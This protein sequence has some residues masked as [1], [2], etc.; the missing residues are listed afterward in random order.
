MNSCMSQELFGMIMF[1]TD[2]AVVCDGAGDSVQHC[3]ERHEPWGGFMVNSVH[4]PVL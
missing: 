2:G 3:L 4:A 1:M